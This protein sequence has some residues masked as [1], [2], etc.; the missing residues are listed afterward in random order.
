MSVQYKYLQTRG[1]SNYG[2]ISFGSC[3][4][5]QRP[6]HTRPLFLTLRSCWTRPITSLG[7]Q[8]WRKV[9]WGAQIF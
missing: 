9:F 8:G 3:F 5:G 2:L 4:H 1:G 6:Q 7:H